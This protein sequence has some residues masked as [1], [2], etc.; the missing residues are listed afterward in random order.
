MNDRRARW[1]DTFLLAASHPLLFAAL[2]VASRRPHLRLG[3]TT[4]ISDPTLVRAVLTGAALDRT[5]PGTTGATI[6]EALGAEVLF[7]GAPDAHRLQRAVLV[8]H[9]ARPELAAQFAESLAPTAREV[10]EGH[11][12]D[13][14][15]A[16]RTAAA[17]S[18]AE[19]LGV[20]TGPE[21]LASM[22]DAVADAGA[23]AQLTGRGSVR[24]PALE[25]V[26][27][28]RVDA[29]GAGVIS[30]MELSV[31]ATTA[32]A[33]AA[34][35]AVASYVTSVAAATRMVAFISDCRGWEEAGASP[36]A[37]VNDLLGLLAP[38]PVLPRSLAESWCG[39]GLEIPSGARVV[40]DVRAANRRGDAGTAAS[41]AHLA[42]GFG[43][44]ACPGAG[45]ARRQL[46]TVVS[47]LAPCAPVVVRRR[48]G[49][50]RALPRWD[51]L[52][53]EASR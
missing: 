32:D 37:A 20:S 38:S 44:H 26:E 47:L 5:G 49:R 8:R 39:D 50:G 1:R 18:V 42:F 52:V 24:G 28:L 34:V 10:A 13:L 48:R 17:T 6:A 19:L 43:P 30:E 2:S 12:V 25:L 46:E 21:R 36:T 45:A 15:P 14:A 40:L 27:A 51:V 53:V 29:T 11:R 4:V 35:T 41:V 22:I 31:D 7:A 9:L 16:F 33:A 3:S 23:Q